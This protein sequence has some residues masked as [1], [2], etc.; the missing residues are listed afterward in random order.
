[1]RPSY[2]WNAPARPLAIDMALDVVSRL[3]LEAMEAFKAVPRRGLEVGGLLL[4]RIEILNGT[5]TIYIDDFTAVES[6]HRSGPSYRLSEAD[7]E[8][9]G[10][11]LANHPDAVGI[12]RTQT[13]SQ[14]LAIQPD[15]TEIFER[16]FTREEDLFLL[17]SPA[18]SKAAFFLPETHQLV[19]VHEFP[20]RAADLAGEA[21][22][23]APAPPP[24]EPELAPSRAAALESARLAASPS[25]PAKPS[26]RAGWRWLVAA[27][28]LVAGAATGALIYEHFP[29][30]TPGAT[31]SAS[32]PPA[33]S[34][35]SAPHVALRV[36]RDGSA[37]RLLWDRNSP[38]VR[39]SD[40][41]TLYISD[42]KHQSTL[43]LNRDELNSGAVSYWP[44]TQDVNF[45]LDVFSPHQSSED[46]IHVAG[47][48]QAAAATP[49]PAP[50]QPQRHTARDRASARKNLADASPAKPQH[51]ETVPAQDTGA[52]RDVLSPATKPPSPSTVAALPAAPVTSAR[53]LE[54]HPAVVAPAEP[55]P[56]ITV[57]AQPVTPS[58]V[59][60]VIG[61]I[62]LV[63]RL[64]KQ[65]AAFVP[66]QPVHH[67]QPTLDAAERRSVTRS[68]PVS[69]RVYVTDTGA[70]DYAQLISGGTGRFGGLGTA[71]VYTARH[72][73]FVPA[74]LGDEKVA[75]EVILHFRFAPPPPPPPPSAVQSSSF[76][77]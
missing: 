47:M 25:P 51:I 16:Y 76:N 6:E 68:V 17:I 24:E 32:A 74:R 43:D 39:D 7:L 8:R 66:P 72:W 77:H 31:S 33:S 29:R 60:E 63:R 50:Q 9:L 40:H 14:E 11:E 54:T 61:R 38:I 27:A 10:A 34:T 58:R 42:G 28:A 71:A 23:E 67:P 13:R 59:E 49:A 20:F 44:E 57:T 5:T 3:G 69:V 21:V 4:G 30:L 19:S 53:T 18:D 55:Q 45:R 73:S 64:K 36:E 56:D 35:N 22:V 26:R 62:P 65:K 37:L 15:D 75:S 52:S 2:V 46:S 1:M 70:V 12:Y 48:L 41:A